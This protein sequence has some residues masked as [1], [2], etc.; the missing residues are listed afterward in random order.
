MSRLEDQLA[1]IASSTKTNCV[2]GVG[3]THSGAASKRD[4]YW[5]AWF[6]AS[7]WGH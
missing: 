5:F 2:R 4:A 1:L 6:K 3:A 7:H